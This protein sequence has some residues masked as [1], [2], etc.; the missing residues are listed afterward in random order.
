MARSARP[1]PAPQRMCHDEH[2]SAPSGW[3]PHPKNPVEEIWWD[4]TAWTGDSRPSTTLPAPKLS[5][6]PVAAAQGKPAAHKN[7]AVAAKAKPTD[8]GR[9]VQFVLGGVVVALVMAAIVSFATQGLG[10]RSDA[11]PGDTVAAAGTDPEA[12]TE[13]SAAESARAAEVAA[14]REIGR[15]SCRER[16][17]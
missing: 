10:S 16:V 14:A 11:D 9:R 1:A 15:A 13:T 6:E 3:Y 5:P 2:M 17:F 7:A 12:E 4:G 8:S